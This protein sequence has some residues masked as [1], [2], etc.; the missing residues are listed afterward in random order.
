M[1]PLYAQEITDSSTAFFEGT[2][3]AYT[4]APPNGFKLLI[5]EAR[6]DGYSFAMVPDA[7]SYDVAD[8]VVLGTYLSMDAEASSEFSLKRFIADDT[9]QMR[10]YFGEQLSINKVEG[11][12]NFGG[13]TLQTVYLNDT[14]QF[15]PTVMISYFF[16][17]RELFIF[18]LVISES[19]PRFKAED[20]Y[21][22][23]LY[24]FKALKKGDLSDLTLQK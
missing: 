7:A 21:I 3:H 24:G 18:E 2:D 10:D 12:T 20:V 15:I 17:P 19:Y 4:V 16:R 5:D 6:R 11:I 22:E 9:A 1:S 8:L 13:D 14:T 23:A